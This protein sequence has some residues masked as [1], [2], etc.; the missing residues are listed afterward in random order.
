MTTFSVSLGGA[1]GYGGAEAR[2]LSGS[3]T[4]TLVV[5]GFRVTIDAT[6]IAEHG[7]YLTNETTNRPAA[8]T[9][10]PRTTG[11]LPGR[12]RF[13]S[14]NHFDFTVSGDGTFGYDGSLAAY[15]SG[16]G[17]TTLTVRG[18]AI[19]FDLTH[20]DTLGF[21]LGNAGPDTI[22]NDGPHTLRLLP[23]SHEFATQGVDFWFV[24]GGDGTPS[25]TPAYVGGAGT[26]TLTFTGV[27]I[28]INATASSQ[29]FY[30]YADTTVLSHTATHTLRLLPGEHDYQTSTD[31]WAFYFDVTPAGTITLEP[32]KAG[33]SGA[34]TSTVVVT[35]P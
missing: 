9:S 3:G 27:P 8:S 22:Y 4:N 11:L 31:T 15:L 29:D 26:S 16:A 7:W 14:F 21:G 2:Y 33:I 1:V 23:G 25:A 32:G 10:T 18:F 35:G 19:T 24:V 12:H 17:T 28:T 6:P 34:G 30:L 13:E 20:V 5:R